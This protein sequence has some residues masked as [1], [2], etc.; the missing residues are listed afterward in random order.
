M[1]EEAELTDD[2]E[3]AL[4]KAYCFIN[5]IAPWQRAPNR[6]AFVAI[7]QAASISAKP[8]VDNIYPY[9]DS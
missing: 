4:K 8:N 6:T 3:R 5:G 9:L 1:K 7:L 2:V